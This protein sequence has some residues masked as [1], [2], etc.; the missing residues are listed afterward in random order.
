LEQ[1]HSV[2]AEMTDCKPLKTAIRLIVHGVAQCLSL[3][4]MVWT[5]WDSVILPSLIFFSS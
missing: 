5:V 1:L 2:P 4:T 3:Y